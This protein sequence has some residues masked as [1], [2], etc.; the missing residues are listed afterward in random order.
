MVGA[1]LAIAGLS[2]RVIMNAPE[3]VNPA[4]LLGLGSLELRVVM[5]KQFWFLPR[6]TRISPIFH[7]LRVNP[8]PI[9]YFDPTKS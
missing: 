8:W 1:G 9:S 5:E 2:R 4:F 7:T 3:V 6:M